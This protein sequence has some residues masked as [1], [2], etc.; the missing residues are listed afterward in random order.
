MAEEKNPVYIRFGY[1]ESVESKKEVLSSE[2]SLL[3]IM[4]IMR[5]YNSLRNEELRIKAQ[6]YKMIK[7]LNLAVRKTRASFPFLKIPQ[8]AKREEIIL[9]KS[10]TITREHFDTDLENQLRDIQER[11]K[12]IGR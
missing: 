1:D 11:L 8:K 2:M 4:K 10:A 5:R 6:M 12:S 3:N 7:D 9:T